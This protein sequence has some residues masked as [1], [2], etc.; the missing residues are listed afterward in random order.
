V[1]NISDVYKGFMESV[2]KRNFVLIQFNM[3]LGLAI[4]YLAEALHYKP[5]SRGFYSR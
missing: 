5:E 2:H 3:V 1:C 4:A